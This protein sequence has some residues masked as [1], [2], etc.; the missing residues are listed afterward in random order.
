MSKIEEEV[1][2]LAESVAVQF[3]CSVVDCEYKKEGNDW[4]LRVFI[5]KE[6]GV[7]IQDCELVS[8]ALSDVLDQQNLI[9]QAYLFEV[10]SPGLERELKKER[11]F[12]HFLGRKV[13]VKLYAPLDG[14]KEFTAVLEDYQN[15]SAFLRIE[16]GELLEIKKN[17]AAYIRLYAEF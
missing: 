10:C 8:R 7:G 13:S 14:H 2:K 3:E 17:M 1:L 15:G 5:D 4:Y 11:E 9:A 12:L 6:G 16:K